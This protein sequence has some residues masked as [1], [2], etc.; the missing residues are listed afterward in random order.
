MGWFLLSAGIDH[1]AS[2]RWAAQFADRVIAA[3]AF[4]MGTITFPQAC[5]QTEG[6]SV[7]S[8]PPVL[9]PQFDLYKFHG[10]GDD[11]SGTAPTPQHRCGA[12]RLLRQ[13]SARRLMDDG[14][15]GG[16]KCR[17]ETGLEADSSD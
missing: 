15:A 8:V 16:R 11:D 5:H 17:P 7:L 6:A 10:T 2:R 9:V 13:G 14:L 1:V 4:V 12:Q 3:E